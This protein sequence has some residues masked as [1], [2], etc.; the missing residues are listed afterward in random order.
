[1]AQVDADGRECVISYVSRQLSASERKYDTRQKEV[2]AAVWECDIFC[3]Y[4]LAVQFTVETNHANLR[5]LMSA[6]HQTSRLAR[7][8]LRLQEFDFTTRHKPGKA[9]TNSD[10]LSCLPSTGSAPQSS[11]DAPHMAVTRKIIDLPTLEDIRFQQDAETLL[12]AVIDFL[13]YPKH[14]IASI[15]V[16]EVLRDSGHITVDW[17]SSLSM[18]I[19][20]NNNVAVTVNDTGRGPKISI[21]AAS[22]VERR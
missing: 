6:N 15:E 9:N 18:D 13:K 16:K 7:W 20:F 19:F 5:W 1:M 3:R 11:V 21:S 17:N 12:H 4:L 8:I 14:R 22:K 10:P 2:L